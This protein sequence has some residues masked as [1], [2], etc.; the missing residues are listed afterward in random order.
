MQSFENRMLQLETKPKTR[1][2]EYSVKPQGDEGKSPTAPP[3]AWI[4]APSQLNPDR[5]KIF[6]FSTK[7]SD[8]NFGVNLA[9][10]PRFLFGAPTNQVVFPMAGPRALSQLNPD[11]DKI[12]GF[13]ASKNFQGAS[14][15]TTSA[16]HGFK[17]GALAN[18]QAPPAS[19]TAPYSSDAAYQAYLQRVF[20]VT[21]NQGLLKRA[22]M[23]SCSPKPSDDA[24][25]QQYVQRVLEATSNQG[26]I[27]NSIHGGRNFREK[28]GCNPLAVFVNHDCTSLDHNKAPVNAHAI[29][30]VSQH[31]P[32]I[33]PHIRAAWDKHPD[34]A[35]LRDS[36]V[37]GAASAA[38]YGYPWDE[39]AHVK[40]LTTIWE[41]Q[42]L[43]AV[44]K[45]KPPLVWS[46]QLTDIGDNERTYC[47]QRHI[48][49]QALQ[50]TWSSPDEGELIEMILRSLQISGVGPIGLSQQ[51]ETQHDISSKV[52]Y[53]QGGWL[54]SFVFKVT[55]TRFELK[56]GFSSLDVRI[57]PAALVEH[58][59][60]TMLPIVFQP[61]HTRGYKGYDD[62]LLAALRD[63]AAD[64]R[65]CSS[66]WL[67]HFSLEQMDL[68]EN[69]FLPYG[70]G[71]PW[72]DLINPL[73][74]DLLSLVE[75][76]WLALDSGVMHQDEE[77]L[78][79]ACLPGAIGFPPPMDGDG[80]APYEPDFLR[81]PCSPPPDSAST[82]TSGT[83]G[84]S[85]NCRYGIS[86]ALKLRL[87]H[88][89]SFRRRH[90]SSC[91]RALSIHKCSDSSA[92]PFTH[93]AL[94]MRRSVF[95]PLAHFVAH[96][97]ASLLS[98]V[99]GCNYTTPMCLTP[100]LDAS[101]W[102]EIPLALV[103]DIVAY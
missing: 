92:S 56:E 98:S 80:V 29:T 20:D 81:A 1:I 31:I 17:F 65:Q 2:S 32:E 99:D 28:P 34:W 26:L 4:T 59:R 18:L 66:G 82:P 5:D 70:Q 57:C 3:T 60:A 73:W 101:A 24:A 13:S 68:L 85:G 84:V 95:Y 22:P 42:R 64:P 44:E 78:P 93:I 11:R 102:V 61:F 21:S 33:S 89:L 86:P 14:G 49:Q 23:K 37:A 94:F 15:A 90:P 16:A 9:S 74:A 19:F 27:K 50:Q 47:R 79:L 53:V 48:S 83:V 12:F 91:T 88:S 72:E 77:R 62:Q 96:L 43:I 103:G 52:L 46:A 38:K 30:H 58:V 39:T 35:T 8:Q 36:I 10:A 6:N 25:Y 41:R 97:V 45:L 51:F 7:T 100:P 76:A 67:G 40:Y 71:V 63:I 75:E 87:Q 69:I 54:S 55:S